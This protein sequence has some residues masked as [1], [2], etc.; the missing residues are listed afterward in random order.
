MKE[1]FLILGKGRW[2]VTIKETVL[3]LGYEAT[4]LGGL[5]KRE[6]ES[7]NDYSVRW[8]ALLSSLDAEVIWI[9][10]PPGPH[11]II[12]SKSIL[13]AGKNLIIEKPW[14]Y[15][16]A[17]MEELEKLALQKNLRVAI[18]YQYVY[19]SDFKKLKRDWGK[20]FDD[21]KYVD[22]EFQI[23][24]GERRDISIYENL[25]SHLLSLHLCFFQY[26]GVRSIYLGSGSTDNRSVSFF[27]SSNE[28]LHKIDFTKNSEPILERFILEYLRSITNK[29]ICIP[30]LK[31][32][33]QIYENLEIY[34]G[35]LKVL[36]DEK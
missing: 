2:G 34:K 15:S 16:T 26:C 24:R 4:S 10:T 6:K 19:L 9:A 11:V 5:R 36:I 20:R 25:A 29:S 12:L 1:K 35:S 3:R 7:W 18:N 22:L 30:D 32:A 8:S 28:L 13:L 21:C 17:E 31:F 33:M 27:N 14:V 23:S